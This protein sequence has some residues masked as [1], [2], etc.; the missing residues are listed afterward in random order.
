M[1]DISKYNQIFVEKSWIDKKYGCDF[2]LKRNVPV[3]QPPVLHRL[4]KSF[5]TE[6]ELYASW[7][8]I[9][10]FP[11]TESHETLANLLC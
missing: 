4:P 1:E 2:P 8:K 5:Q 6:R 3:V 11:V 7:R 10:L 9:I